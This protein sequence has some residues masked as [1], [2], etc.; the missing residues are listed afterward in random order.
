MGNKYFSQRAAKPKGPPNTNLQ[1]Q[2][3]P[4]HKSECEIVRFVL[5]SAQHLDLQLDTIEEVSDYIGGEV[6][7]CIAGCK[8]T[9]ERTILPWNNV[10]YI[11]EVE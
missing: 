5:K 9:G 1:G 11:E 7:M 10:D 4:E 8:V 6:C 3:W 2:P